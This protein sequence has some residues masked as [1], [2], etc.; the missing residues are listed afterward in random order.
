MRDRRA[1]SDR[2]RGTTLLL[3]SILGLLVAPGCG[4]VVVETDEAL[5]SGTTGFAC[6]PASCP[7]GCCDERGVCRA[8][9]DGVVVDSGGREPAVDAGRDASRES[10]DGASTLDASSDAS[11]FD[12]GQDAGSRDAASDAARDAGQNA[13]A[14]SC[15]RAACPSGCCPAATCTHGDFTG[16]GETDLLARIGD[17]LVRYRGTG[18]GLLVQDGGEQI[19]AGWGGYTDFLSPGDFDGDGKADVLTRDGAGRIRLFPGDGAGG[20]KPGGGAEVDSGWGGR[21]M[22]VAARDWDGDGYNDVLAKGSDGVLLLFR[23][24]G[25]GGFVQDGGSPL[26]TWPYQ[27][28]VHVGDFDAD[29]H[30]DLLAQ[31]ADGV[32]FLCRGNGCGGFKG[33]CTSLGLQWS[34]YD[35]IL[36]AGDF[37]GDGKQDVLTRLGN[38][39]G[40]LQLHR[41]NGAGGFL[42]NAPVIDSNWHI[43]DTLVS[44]W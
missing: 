31:A 29:G 32:L 26:T 41:G 2:R 37:D 10:G 27:R 8:C 1:R 38:G 9:A 43:V 6:G 19:G 15:V 33:A 30:A 3:A 36:S 35:I 40:V 42:P 18:G 25:V 11:T 7:D 24:N 28:T 14:G 21:S 16:D 39:A 20:L 44:A 12:G 34:Q 17:V 22:F 13:D 4:R 5:D 23:G